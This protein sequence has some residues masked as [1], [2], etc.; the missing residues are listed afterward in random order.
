MCSRI[1]CFARVSLATNQISVSGERNVVCFE[2]GRVREGQGAGV[3]N[4][5]CCGWE[6]YGYFPPVSWSPHVREQRTETGYSE[7]KRGDSG[8]HVVVQSR[9]VPMY[10][11]PSLYSVFWMNKGMGEGD[12]TK[13]CLGLHR[14]S[15]LKYNSC[16]YQV[17]NRGLKKLGEPFTSP[18]WWLA[19]LRVP[20]HFLSLPLAP[21]LL[22]V[23]SWWK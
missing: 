5:T 3:W 11:F 6:K 4:V 8:Q 22:W 10:F 23:F 19:P 13:S 9:A 21:K 1:G 2:T 7:G 12:I 20:H 18:K 14:T 16:I 15:D 17:G